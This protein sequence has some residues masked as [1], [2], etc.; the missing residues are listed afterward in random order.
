MLLESFLIRAR[1][2]SLSSL[3]SCLML[4]DSSR[5]VTAD[6]PRDWSIALVAPAAAA[7]CLALPRPVRT[8]T[9][10]GG[11]GG[12][13]GS[14]NGVRA[15]LFEVLARCMKDATD[16]MGLVL[17]GASKLGQA[18]SNERYLVAPLCS[19]MIKLQTEAALSAFHCC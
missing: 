9:S 17:D 6:T 15:T 11:G 5:N 8:V 18:V 1:S 7:L 12:G 14:G 19:T 13:T 2:S 3:S 16:L 10:V 4:I